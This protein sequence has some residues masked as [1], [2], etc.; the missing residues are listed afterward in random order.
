MR[1]AAGLIHCRTYIKED[2]F[3]QQGEVFHLERRRGE[4]RSAMGAWW[5]GGRR[6][7]ARTEKNKEK[8]GEVGAPSFFFFVW[9]VELN[10]GCLHKLGQRVIYC[11]LV[12]VLV[13]TSPKKMTP[14]FPV[15][16]TV[17]TVNSSRRCVT[18]LIS[19]KQGISKFSARMTDHW[20]SMIFLCLLY[21]GWVSIKPHSF[22]CV[23]CRSKFRPPGCSSSTLTI[24]LSC[25][26]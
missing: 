8:V 21:T 6:K 17:N 7:K 14:S 16:I 23:S 12:N 22:I 15:T 11:S 26:P 19:L 20:T 10:Y 5:K 18:H 2:S 24:E 4:E 25:Q 1:T 13:D 3:T 9:P